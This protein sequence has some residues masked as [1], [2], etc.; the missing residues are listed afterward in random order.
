MKMSVEDL[1][2][3]SLAILKRHGLSDDDARIVADAVM[4]AELR[5][6]PAHGVIR[7]PGIAERLASRG[8]APMRVARRGGACTLVDGKGNLGYLVAHRCARTAAEKA[9]HGGIGLVGAFNTD[10]CG[11]VGYY[12]SLVVNTGLVCLMACDASPR[13]APW[14]AT[15]PVLGPN[16]LA[17]GFPFSG[18]Q[19]L[20]DLST[21]AVTNGDILMAMK[22]GRRIPDGCALDAEGRLTT[23]PQAAL[24]GAALPFGGH[25]GYALGLVVQV[26]ASA[27]VGAA[28]VPRP[29]E[30]YGLLMLALSP[31]VFV[32]REAFDRGVGEI[33]R[34]VKGARR[35][36]PATEVLIPGERAFRERE[37]RL[38]EG[39]AVEA[40]VMGELEKLLR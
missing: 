4:E 1:R 12:V 40:E 18:G 24:R 7:L 21:A 34:R 39:I 37:R 17:V 29:G 20:V 9:R 27:L 19:V 6:R 23:D 14:G 16:P 31:T 33:V 11:M 15:E 3:L 22:T 8:R 10:H 38:K 26:L 28:P 36:D 5:G 13:V 25:K 30:N 32:D 35:V 2:G